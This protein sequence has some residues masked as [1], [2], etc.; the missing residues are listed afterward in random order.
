MIG[1]HAE[2]RRFAR[3]P[4]FGNIIRF[5]IEH[6]PANS[7]VGCGARHLRQRRAAH[8][9]EDDAVWTLIGCCL[10]GFQD[11]GALV[12]GIVVRLEYLEVCG[13]I[14]GRLF[15]CIGLL[16]L[17]IVVVGCQRHQNFDLGH[18]H[19]GNDFPPL[20]TLHR[21]RRKGWPTSREFQKEITLPP[22]I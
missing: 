8:W 20:I 15:R 12:D 1:T 16:P 22:G 3:A 14:A 9:L 10:N 19:T 13:K 17:V 5:A 4:E 2:D 18:S 21:P 6:R 7:S 11:L